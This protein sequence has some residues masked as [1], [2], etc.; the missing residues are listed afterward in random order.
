MSDAPRAATATAT[1]TATVTATA[2]ATGIDVAALSAEFGAAPTLGTLLRWVRDRLA[3]A[4]IEDAAADARVLVGAALGLDRSALLLRRDAPVPPGAAGA[5][6]GLVA[7]RLA[8]EPV[9]RILGVREFWSLE[10]QV[11]ADVLDPRPDTETVVEAALAW[12]QDTGP[13][14]RPLRVLDLGTGSGCLLLA[15]LSELHGARGLG[16]DRSP[17][18]AALAR[19]NA[20]R[21][22]LSDRAAMVVGDWADAVRSRPPDGE[23]FGRAA[24]ETGAIKTGAIGADASPGGFDLVVSNPPYIPSAEIPDLAPEVRDH[25]PLLALD[26]AV[27]GLA[28]YRRIAADLPRLLR[29]GGLVALEVGRGQDAA[30]AALL[31]EAG[32]DAPNLRHDLRG[33]P[34]CVTAKS[35][36]GPGTVPPDASPKKPIGCSGH[37]G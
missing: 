18:A 4:R 33:V 32:L 29:P 15:V 19:A 3:A 35:R 13:R 31:R 25:D 17:A 27:D 2:T 37:S 9:S 26:G 21:L 8:R 30:V 14:D 7:R 28:A 1:A 10:F 5:V 6:A 11:T 22:G 24:T 20:R 23:L 12:V 36:P 16:I 34:R